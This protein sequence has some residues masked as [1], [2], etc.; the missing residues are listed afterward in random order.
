MSKVSCESVRD[1][2]LS[3]APLSDAE[4]AHTATCEQ[5]SELVV[6]DGALGRAL[7]GDRASAEPDPLLWAELDASLERETGVRAWLRSRPTPTRVALAMATF[8]L[9]TLLGFRRVRSDWPSVSKLEVAVL[10]AA[11]GLAALFAVRAA[12]PVLG[13]RPSR[14][15]GATLLAAVGL[16]LLAAFLRLEQGAPLATGTA[17]WVQAARCFGYGALL[18]APLFALLWLCDRDGGPRSRFVHA[19]LACGLA[20][21]AALSLHCA[22]ADA[23]H[24][25]IGHA[26]IGL[27]LATA[28]W[29]VVS[30]RERLPRR[31][32]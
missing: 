8:A 10:V 12:L 24:V 11:F 5:C 21:N 31:A 7:A 13:A 25:L 18:A 4:I 22:V 1:A 20:A 30:R 14:E 17:F 2:L 27:V 9:V 15:R 26:S 29:L 19:A 32:P 3:G 23:R 28:A 16:P 6:G